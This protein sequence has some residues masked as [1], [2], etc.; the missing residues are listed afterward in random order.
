MYFETSE[1][2]GSLK[3]GHF[4]DLFGQGVQTCSGLCHLNPFILLPSSD[5]CCASNGC[6]VCYFCLSSV[7]REFWGTI[8]INSSNNGISVHFASPKYL[9]EVCVEVESE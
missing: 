7:C 2:K 8:L 6:P 3:N 4:S 1:N 5:L 9:R